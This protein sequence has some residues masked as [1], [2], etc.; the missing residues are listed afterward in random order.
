MRME[1]Y[2][3]F[4]DHALW[5]VII[6]GDLVSPVASASAGAEGP[7]PPKTTEQ[8]L[9]RK[10]KLKAKSTFMLAIPDEHLLMFH[11]CKYAKSLWEAIKN[12]FG[13]NMESKKMQ[14]TILKQNYENFA[15]SSQKGLDKTYD[16][17]QKLISQFEIHGKVIS[18]EDAN[19]KLLRSLPSA[20]NNFALI[21]R[22]KSNLDTLSMDD[23][24]NNLKVYESEIKS[25]SNSSS[26]SQNVA[27]V[28]L[29]NSSSTNEIVNTTYS[30]S[31]ASF[32]D[33]ASTGSYADD[34]MFSFFSNQSNALQLDNEDLGDDLEEMDLKWQVVKEKQE[35]DK[36]GS[37]PDKN[38]KR[39]SEDENVFKPKEVKKTVKPSLE[40]IEFVN[41]RNTTIENENKA[42]KP[43]KFSQSPMGKITGPKEIR[44][45]WENTA[46][47]NH[48]NKLTHPHPKRNFVP[49][50]FLTKFRQVPLNAAKQSS[51]RAATSV[52]A[53][54]R[55]NTAA[56][57]PNDQGIFD[58]ECSRHMTRNKSYLTDYQ[59]IYGGFVAFKGN[60]K[61]EKS[62]EVPRKK[63]G[64]QDPAKECDN[65]DQEKDLRDQV[66]GLRKQHKQEFERLFGQGEAAN[67]NNT[68]RLNTVSLLVNAVS[69]FFTTVD[70]RRERTQRNEFESMFGQYKDANGNKMFTPISAAGSTYVNLGGSILVNAATLH[71]ADLRTNP[72]MPD[73][74]DTVDLHDTGIFNGA[75]DDKVKGKVVDFNELE[76]TIV[77]SKHAI[78]TKWVYR[79]K[80]DERWIV[81]R[82]KARLVAQEN[83][84]RRGITDKNL[85][86]KNDKGDLLLVHVYVEDII[87]GSTKKSLC[88]EFEGLMHKKF[89]ISFIGELIFFLGLKV[90]Q[91]DDGNFISQ[92]KYVADIL[93]TFNFSLVKITSTLI[94]TNKTLIKD[95]E[96]EDV[97][98]Y[99][100][101]SMIE[102][103]MLLTLSFPS[104]Q[105]HTK[106]KE[107]DK[108]K[109]RKNL[110]REIN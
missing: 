95:E 68:N 105:D 81:V 50:V 1:Q 65:N 96:A 45:V 100:Y 62:T 76:L 106:Y 6:N 87:F 14:K 93:K 28:S 67:T 37:K 51:H 22:N 38:R 79:N 40:K 84:F 97:D 94:E 66:D 35:K 99:L 49:A 107:E 63:N 74:E 69:S 10:N 46:R 48:Q 54:R 59:E 7:I 29:D 36:I 23:L 61:G 25:Q 64:V 83:G 17:F 4:T 12:R 58:S 77:V 13:G 3:T 34:V 42:E 41:A 21:M 2:L 82:N 9:A 110:E 85:F 78:E 11:A 53:A 20:W 24:Y 27:F 72:L 47:M 80:K 33:Q 88:T 39:D 86:I 92:D 55:I 60:A 19:L 101:R 18:Q 104:Q 8:K 30:V 44:L 90:M 71:N 70:P 108:M 43:K 15:S 31:D 26:N 73:L 32:K 5:E 103:L 75:Y 57:R 89:Q 98:V 91:R 109:T 56:S 52:S 16:R 102:S